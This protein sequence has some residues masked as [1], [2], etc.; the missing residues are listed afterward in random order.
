M[1]GIANVKPNCH[2]HPTFMPQL[3]NEAFSARG[4]VERKAVTEWINGS[5]FF[6][7]F[8][9]VPHGIIFSTAF[10]IRDLR[11]YALNCKTWKT[12]TS[13]WISRQTFHFLIFYCYDRHHLHTV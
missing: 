8:L 1:F 5:L 7:L 2:V 10:A 12:L 11:D 4:N 13:N 3:G 9:E 6:F